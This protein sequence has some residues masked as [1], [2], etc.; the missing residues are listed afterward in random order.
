MKQLQKIP[1]GS[2]EILPLTAKDVLQLKGPKVHT[3]GPEETALAATQVLTTHSIGTLLVV[4]GGHN[5]VGILSE[6]D[7][8]RA[9]AS[10]FDGLRE[11]KV[12]DL[13]TTRVIVGLVEDSLDTVMSIMTDKRIR[14]LPIVDDGK[15]AGILSIGDM[16]KARA[17]HAEVAARYLS[18]YIRGTYP[19]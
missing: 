18:D 7:V 14:H 19:S 6:R 13:M 1:T 11:R 2:E 10:D 8:L 5:I 16:V 12:S 17:H 4:D 9:M 3:I 15:L